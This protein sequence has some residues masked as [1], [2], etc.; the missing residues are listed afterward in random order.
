[1]FAMAAAAATLLVLDLVSS[2]VGEA[3]LRVASDEV[4]SA[5]VVARPGKVSTMQS[6]RDVLGV[7][8]S[9][10]L[11]G[12]DDGSCASQVGA[13]LGANQVISGSATRL[14]AQTFVQLRL[15]D[16]VDGRVLQRSAAQAAD[17]DDL[18]DAV[19]RATFE[20]LGEAYV[21][22]VRHR[23]ERLYEA[24]VRAGWHGS[25]DR[26]GFVVAAGWW[27][28]SGAFAFGPEASFSRTFGEASGTDLSGFADSL[29][30]VATAPT[31]VDVG[32]DAAWKPRLSDHVSIVLQLGAGLGLHGMPGGAAISPSPWLRPGAGV[33]LNTS[34]DVSFS[35]EAGWTLASGATAVSVKSFNEF[36]KARDEAVPMGTGGPEALV[37]VQLAL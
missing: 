37:G 22:A 36:G 14:G 27:W 1:M 24:F 11:V 8:A 25:E 31:R 12:C 32:F 23:A 26:H 3:E 7:E 34:G 4:A 16:A 30:P 2:G 13:S 5:A 21:P 9:R 29:P 33:R 20:L 15:I 10:A 28:R 6:V 17:A 35:L 18:P 19:R